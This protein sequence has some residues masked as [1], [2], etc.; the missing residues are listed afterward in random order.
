[1]RESK[2]GRVER[3]REGERKRRERERREREKEEGEREEEGERKRREKEEGERKRRERERRERER[4]GREITAMYTQWFYCLYRA[5]R[6]TR[7]LSIGAG[8]DEVMLSIICKL[9]GTLPK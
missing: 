4:G 1:M 8:A 7:L 3:E 6:D 2:E 5:W 9:S